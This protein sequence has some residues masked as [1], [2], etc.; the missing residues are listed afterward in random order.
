MMQPRT[1]IIPIRIGNG[2]VL[3][4]QAT[5]LGGEEDVAFQALP[6]EGVTEVIEELS[7]ALVE[8]IARVRPQKAAVEFGIEVAAEAG[9]LTALLVKGSGTAS[10]KVTLEWGDG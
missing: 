8:S 6:L 10:L 1:E 2:R 7:R 3:Q 9:Q 5:V 4:A